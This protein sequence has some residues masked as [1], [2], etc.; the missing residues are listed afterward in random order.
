MSQSIAR[1]NKRAAIKKAV[2]EVVPT[3]TGVVEPET[4]PVPKVYNIVIT[5]ELAKEFD[6]VMDTM[7]P[8]R[9]RRMFME[10]IAKCPRQEIA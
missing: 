7:V 4:V 8:N 10:M 1:K 6:E 2:A 9:Y 3:T 5:P